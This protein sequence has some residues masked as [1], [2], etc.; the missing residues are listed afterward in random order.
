[1]TTVKEHQNTVIGTRLL[2]RED[3]ALL[4]GE[5]RFTNDLN[6]PGALHLS[7]LRSPHAHATIIAIDTTAALKLPGVVA[8]YSGR[9]RSMW[10]TDAMCLAGDRRHEESAT[11]PTRC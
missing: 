9:L 5:A 8:V 10:R 2:R 3:P 1:M 6:I 11:L 7:V 4:T